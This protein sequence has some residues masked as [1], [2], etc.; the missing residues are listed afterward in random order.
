MDL[1]PYKRVMFFE[2]NV[3]NISPDYVRSATV[4]SMISQAF[5]CIHASLV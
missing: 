4:L 1:S 2:E 3:R 5:D